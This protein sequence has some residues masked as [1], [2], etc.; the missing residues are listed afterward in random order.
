[1]KSNRFIPALIVLATLLVAGFI[2]AR[3]RQALAQARER[4]RQEHR[5]QFQ[6]CAE[7]VHDY[8]DAV[9]ALLLFVSLDK[10]VV[11]LR[12]NSEP[13]IEKLFEHGLEQNRLTEVYIVEHDFDGSK[14]PFMTF[15]RGSGDMQAKEV[16]A[17]EREQDEYR[18][19]K[20]HL[21]ELKSRPGVRALLSH[22]VSLC[23]PAEDGSQARG[24]VYSVPIRSGENFAGLVAGMLQTTTIL[25]VLR[26]AGGNYLPAL[27]S[28][29][30]QTILDSRLP[31]EVRQWL[32]SDKVRRRV[33]DST[34]LE[35]LNEIRELQGWIALSAPA[36]LESG[37]KWS[38]VYFYQSAQETRP[39]VLL[40]TASRAALTGA[41]L[42]AGLAL[43]SLVTTL[44]RRVTEQALHLQQRKELERQVQEVSDREQRRA[45]EGLHEDICQ[46]LA[47]IEA[48]AKVLGKK[49]R[50][51]GLPESEVVT[52]L[53]TDIRDALTTTRQM[54]DELQPVSLLQDGFVA[55]IGKLADNLRAKKRVA[56]TVNAERFPEMLDPTVGTHLYRIAQEALSNAVQHANASTVAI[57]LAGTS[58]GVVLEVKDN[59]QGFSVQEL[60]QNAMGLRIMRYRSELIGADLRIDSTPGKGTVVSC[61]CPTEPTSPQSDNTR[62]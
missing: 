11:A 27:V 2:F 56:C 8:F 45:G 49:M 14:R 59:G 6:S 24:H 34:R 52:E 3:E 12:K 9:Y 1:M 30:G 60:R 31:T 46:R 37:D 20:Q 36:N 18:V 32:T 7:H 57:K 38:L 42:V 26:G 53:S 19:Q 39:N 48:V 62:A 25:E 51:A 55:A 61:S 13:Y 21:A 47:G 44:N 28:E 40:G 4:V 29:R 58:G 43:A 15:E 23:A 22:E 54:A 10:D 16:H 17:W 5:L 35:A 41:V 33:C 50:A